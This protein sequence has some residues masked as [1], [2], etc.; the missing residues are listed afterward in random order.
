M[1]AGCSTNLFDMKLLKPT[2]RTPAPPEEPSSR[3]RVSPAKA[4]S[5]AGN[6]PHHEPLC[7]RPPVSLPMNSQCLVSPPSQAPPSGGTSLDG[8]QAPLWKRLLDITGIAL[9]APLLVPLAL[10]LALLIKLVSPGPALFKQERVGFRGRRFLCFKFR[11]MVAN[12][13]ARQHAGHVVQL[14]ASG[15]PMVKLD[16]AGDNRLIRGGGLLRA[17]GLDELPQLLNVFK[18]EMSLVG[19]RPCI[20]Y[21]CEQYEPR[22]WRRF[23]TLPGLTGLWQVSGKNRTTFEE[24]IALDV[25]Y[26]DHKSVFLDLKIMAWTPAAIL[27]QV[28]ETKLKRKLNSQPA[29]V[30]GARLSHS[31]VGLSDLKQGFSESRLNEASVSGK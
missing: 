20:A 29:L 4:T 7:S 8:L 22:H 5:F 27:V 3:W 30:Q 25:H 26:V 16:T 14:M 6:R 15:R 17:L 11:T 21:E 12:A 31:L 19:P 9:A 18:G 28:W 2:R 23:D 1:L 24:M 13:D 10:F